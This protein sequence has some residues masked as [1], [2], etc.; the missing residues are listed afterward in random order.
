M[1]EYLDKYEDCCP[2][3]GYIHGAT[4]NGESELP[5]GSILRGRYIIGTVIRARDTDVFYNGW[6]ALFERRVII[7]E[8]F[9]R[10]CAARSINMELSIYKPDVYEKGMNLFLNQSRELI[11]FYKD[12]DIIT[13]HACFTANKTAYAVM[14]YQ[15]YHTLWEWRQEREVHVQDA[16]EILKKAIQIMEKCHQEDF[17]YIT[18]EY[19]QTGFLHG[20]TD[21][22]SFW[23]TGDGGLVLKD[24]GPWRYISGTPGIVGYCDANESV[25]VYRLAL[26][27]CQLITGKMLE[28]EEQ[29]ESELMKNRLRLKS[30]K[31]NALENALKHNTKDLQT[32]LGELESECTVA[33]RRKQSDARRS[34]SL[35][36]WTWAGVMGLAILM[37]AV[38][39]I[40]VKKIRLES[41]VGEL[42]QNK[43]RVPNVIGMD[44]DEAEKKLYLMGLKLERDSMDYSDEVEEN[45]ISYQIPSE[46]DLQ[47]K[48]GIVVVCIS[49][50]KKKAEVPSVQ[51]LDEG[52]ARKL[53]TKAGFSKIIVEEES[54]SPQKYGTVLSMKITEEGT[55][56][57]KELHSFIDLILGGK[58][59]EEAQEIENR[60]YALDTEIVLT[61]SRRK[62]KSDEIQVIIPELTGISVME[63][64]KRLNEI[65]KKT[66][67]PQIQEEYSDK[68][69]GE[70][71]MQEP[72][73]NTKTTENFVKLVV[74]KG[75]EKVFVRNIGLMTREEAELELEALGLQIGSITEVY[76]DTVAAGKVISQ[77]VEQDIQVEKGSKIDLVVSKG[78]KSVKQE[79]VKIESKP[80]PTSVP[81]QTV[82]EVSIAAEP[83]ETWDRKASET[84]ESQEINEEITE[85]AETIAEIETKESLNLTETSEE[86]NGKNAIEV[87]Q[88]YLEPETKVIESTIPAPP[89]SKPDIIVEPNAGKTTN[90]VNGKERE[91]ADFGSGKTV[92]L[93]KP[94]G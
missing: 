46:N 23:I 43:V 41:S 8:Y 39:V 50:G 76:N 48:G 19:C 18:E 28:D 67:I 14:E 64:E 61:V 12:K 13:Y 29:L 24:F 49:K 84:E 75:K 11:R 66:L 70:V 58:V 9:P 45:R 22:E 78:R 42:A 52:E 82:E 87:G 26:M 36:K 65:T 71:I 4:Q 81:K 72:E 57:Q 79:N 10:Y 38:T 60:L 90:T 5:G 15:D 77:S 73:A 2:H 83:T 85:V 80:K 62:L 69:I 59:G 92:S 1:N 93:E 25:D 30:Q 68:P 6:D 21:L 32:F 51:G 54:N 88:K 20:M 94:G 33:R 55:K 16:V 37:M 53:L 31:W 91:I 35:P 3:C 86:D 7:Q 27:F 44:V 40:G 56:E 63:A 89:I 34:L 17:H 74:S 47:E